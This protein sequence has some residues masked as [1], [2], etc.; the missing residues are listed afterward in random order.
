MIIEKLLEAPQ[1]SAEVVESSRN[2][3]GTL[4][5]QQLKGF[6]GLYAKFEISDL[7]TYRAMAEILKNENRFISKQ[8]YD[9]LKGSDIAD[10]EFVKLLDDYEQRE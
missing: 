5:G 9:F 4:N 7:E 3:L 2:L 10:E 8:I 1:L 6:L